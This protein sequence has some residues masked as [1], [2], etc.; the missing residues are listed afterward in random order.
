VFIY[1]SSEA[2]QRKRQQVFGTRLACCKR[3]G[4]FGVR[5]DLHHKT[6]ARFG[7][8]RDEDLEILCRT[9]HDKEH[10]SR[11]LSKGMSALT[12]CGGSSTLAVLRR[13]L[14]RK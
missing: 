6:Y 5:L 8:E 1:L 4:I 13:P 3:C 11:R 10:A 12:D 9:C 2:W 14:R 7:R